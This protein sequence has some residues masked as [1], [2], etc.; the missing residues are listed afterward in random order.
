MIIA[1]TLIGA[2]AII[3]ITISLQIAKTARTN[4]VE[5]LRDE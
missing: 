4:P 2:L 1:S 3:L 5:S